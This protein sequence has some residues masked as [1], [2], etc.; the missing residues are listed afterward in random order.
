MNFRTEKDSIGSK[1]IDNSKYYGIN[2]SRALENFNINSQK[3]NINLIKNIVLI[4]KACAIVNKNLNKLEEIKA[5][6]IIE[7]CNLIL[8]NNY[9]DQFNISS[10]QGGAGTS[11]NMNVNEVIA[12]IALELLG[13]KKG[14]YEFLH[15]LNHVN[16]SQSTN[17]VYPTALKITCI[18][19]IRL[20][21]SNL[22]DLQEEL[23]KKENEYANILKLG[24]TQLMDGVPM[25]V[26]QSFGAYAKA[27]ARDRWRIYKVE[28]RLRQIN[29]GATAIGTGLNAENKY[30]YM[31][32]DQLQKLSGLGL[33]RSDFLIDNTQ[34]LDVFV[35]ASG[36][37]KACATNLLKISND[38]RLLN[39]GP[40]G[41][42]NEIILDAVQAGSSIMPGKINPVIC[43]MIGQISI[44]VMANDLSITTASSMGQLE[45]NAFTPLIAHSILESLEILIYGIKIFE[46]KCIKTLK[47]NE[48][49]CL[50]N[51]E[52][53]TAY[54]TALVNHIGYDKACYIAKKALEENKTIK[55]IVIEENI[56]DQKNL[57][58]IL[59]PLQI[60]KPG[61][62]GK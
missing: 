23:Q 47:V 46:D 20:L 2:T 15:P 5:N 25:M 1:D 33:S 56:L 57:D 44:K 22:A 9:L 34:N 50:Y 8:N 37:L 52:N 55:D 49:K 35:E 42:F 11:T 36:L 19:Y 58:N 10:L 27:I 14:D 45:L 59:N 13:Q 54:A 30:I 41:G 48:E 28:E 60:T 43:E 61:I 31:I 26:G 16:L 29:M 18:N 39:S 3:T 7:A 38:L 6:A 40:K 12:N 62:P 17:D 21:S 32:T 24:R 4:K 53:S 51:L